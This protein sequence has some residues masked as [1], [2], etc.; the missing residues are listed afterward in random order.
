[1]KQ[2]GKL[3]SMSGAVALA[4]IPLF[5]Q[6][7]PEKKPSFDVISIKPT[8][9]NQNG[10]RGGGPRG[11]RYT[12][13]GATLRM[14]LQNAYL[15]QS[16]GSPLAQLQIFGGPNWMD[17]D[18]YD[19][20]ATADCSGGVLSREQV[21][22]M[23]H[24]MLEE[25]FQLKAHME[26]REQ[27]IYNL[28]VGKEGPKLKASAD[29]TPPGNAPSGGPPQ[30]CGPVPP[31]PAPGATPFGPIGQRGFNPLDP[32]F[33]PPRGSMFMMRNSGGLTMQASGVPLQ[34]MVA[35][36]QQQVG[37]PIYDKTDLKA[38]F[39]F[40]LQFSPE[41]LTTPGLPPG[42]TLPLPGGGPPP[43]TGEPA[44]A[45]DPLPSLFTA[46][47]QLGLRLDSARGPVEVLVVD[48]VQKPTEN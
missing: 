6:A 35:F 13:S 7:T 25:R 4:V 23:I 8:A 16:T 33:V 39:D 28:V 29:Q 30:P 20:Q 32:N 46:I 45:A 27:P 47:Q 15:R 12:M 36:L 3:L 11:D 37:R 41:G 2:A 40:K 1:M 22:L 21:Q 43:A 17:S 42:V 31:P 26:T 9:P 24:S 34:Q 19:I 10:F 5:S 14:L 44:V 38:L 48:S 18:R